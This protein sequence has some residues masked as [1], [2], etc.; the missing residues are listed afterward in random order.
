[1]LRR[2]GMYAGVN[3]LITKPAMSIATAAFLTIITAFGYDTKLKAGLQS[4]NAE[5]GILIG[6]MLIPAILLII[7]FFAMFLYPLNGEKWN[8]TKAGLEK[9]HSEKEK[10]YLKGLGFQ[11]SED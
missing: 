2:E 8:T 9:L 7:C 1:A 11:A 5:R 6:W 10:E 4:A 3:S